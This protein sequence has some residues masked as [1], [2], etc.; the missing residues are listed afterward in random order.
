M[1][2]ELLKHFS[3]RTQLP[4]EVEEISRFLVSAG[5]QDSII[6]HPEELDPGELRGTFVQYTTHSGVYSAPEF[7]TLIIYPANAD[8]AEQRVICGKELIHLCDGKIARTNTPGEV[9][10]LIEKLLG[11]LSTEDYGLADIMASVDKL[12]LYQGLAL[13][14]PIAAR[15]VALEKINDRSATVEDIADW[16][17]LPIP[18]VSLV[19]REEWTEVYAVIEQM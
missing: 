16:A 7:V 14:F 4:V 1:F 12:A 15:E 13:L 5:C 8:L 2:Q 9:D 6:L 3:G 18:V 17:Q 10:A 19:L 11:P